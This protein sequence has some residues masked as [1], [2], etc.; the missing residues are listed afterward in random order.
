MFMGY[1]VMGIELT[2]G[3]LIQ[4]FS[5]FLKILPSIFMCLYLATCFPITVLL[6][7]SHK[8]E[9]FHFPSLIRLG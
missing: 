3:I 2:Q 1:L 7:C 5:N 4:Q 8:A 6:Q 9:L